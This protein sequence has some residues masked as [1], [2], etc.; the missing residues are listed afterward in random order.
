MGTEKTL[1]TKAVSGWFHRG[2]HNLG[3]RWP[4]GPVR[5]PKPRAH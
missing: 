1:R 5:P 4:T 2:G 3:C